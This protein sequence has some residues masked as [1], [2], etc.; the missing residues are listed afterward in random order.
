MSLT[1]QGLQVT[2]YVER[3]ILNHRFLMHPHIVQF[4]E[5]NI[6]SLIC[7]PCALTHV[8]TADDGCLM[9]QEILEDEFEV[10]AVVIVMLIHPAGVPY[11]EVSCHCHGV[12]SRR[13]YV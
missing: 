11:I 7:S 6:Q 8:I 3:E 5:V 10:A 9:T 2:K 13:G 1:T 12:C 4:K